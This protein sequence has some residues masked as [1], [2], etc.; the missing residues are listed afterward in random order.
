MS[1]PGHGTL[2]S[3]SVRYTCTLNYLPNIK[4]W[5][6]KL[7]STNTLTSP[8]GT[9]RAAENVH[10]FDRPPLALLA[11][12]YQ[13]D[14]LMM[15]FAFFSMRLFQDHVAMGRSCPVGADSAVPLASFLQHPNGR[16]NGCLFHSAN[17]TLARGLP[18]DLNSTSSPL[19]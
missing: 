1:L 14:L 16:A 6:S 8:R 15:S 7:S 9:Q 18:Q 11:R 17:L 5:S 12:R 2:G 19:E 10:V 13:K 3:C 4:T